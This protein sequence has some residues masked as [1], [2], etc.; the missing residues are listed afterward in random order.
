MKTER[1][2]A[3]A[4]RPSQCGLRSHEEKPC[5][6]PAD[7][8]SSGIIPAMAFCEW[9]WLKGIMT[10]HAITRVL[11]CYSAALRKIASRVASR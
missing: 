4:V 10:K 2:L 6:Q 7:C 9:T 3:G 5:E 1:L 11:A 8:R